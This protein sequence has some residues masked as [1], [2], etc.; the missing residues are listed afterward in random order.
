MTNTINLRLINALHLFTVLAQCILNFCSIAVD[1]N[2]IDIVL[3]PSPLTKSTQ[4]VQCRYGLSVLSLA[5]LYK[6]YEHGFGYL[7]D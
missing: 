7:P 3:L 1:E 6:R 4:S 5:A 2:Y